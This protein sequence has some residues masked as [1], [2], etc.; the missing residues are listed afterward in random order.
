MA[1]NTQP[2]TVSTLIGESLGAMKTIFHSERNNDIVFREF[3]S[4]TGTRFFVAYIDGMSNGQ[5]INEFILKP[6]MLNQSPEKT[7]G[8]LVQTPGI[9]ATVSLKDAVTGILNGDAVLF[10]D[11]RDQCLILE[12]KGFDARS[13]SEPE[14]EKAI[15]GSRESFTESIRTNT[16]LIHRILRTPD[17]CCEFMQIG[18]INQGQCA[19]MYLDNVVNQKTLREV[20]KRLE[21]IRGDF[22][23]GSGMVEQLIEDSPLSLFPS[24]LST[25][26]PDRA[27]GYL[28]MGRI[29]ILCDGSPQAIVVPVS[30]A[31]LLDSPEGNTQRWQSGSLSRLI[32]MFAFFCSTMLSAL[33]L[34]LLIYHREMIPTQLLGNI[35]VARAGIPFPSIIEVLVMEL[36]FELV[37]E[38]G[39]RSPNA[40][41]S[42]MGIVGAL[43]LGQSAVEANLVS[44]VTLI[45]VAL[46]G[47]GNIA[48][49]DYDLAFGIRII[50]LLFILGASLL[51]FL[52]I[53][54]VLVITLTLLGSQRS[55][56]VSMLSMQSVCWDSGNPVVFQWP[57]WKLRYRPR[58]LHVQ[59]DEAYP[60]ISR[61]WTN[62]GVNID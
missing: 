62:D 59:R 45:V 12:A 39:L 21:E 26:R 49:P 31:L 17:L 1:E 28:A 32:R 5:T 55:F 24:I 15:K 60:K 50:K 52:G 7:G 29:V 44:P 30:L 61:K 8:Q 11:G 41:G 16:T 57:L 53:A 54:I 36:F 18:D 33:Y 2:T 6:V 4:G 27:S 14:T 47:L 43:I 10:E 37:R 9:N 3:Q 51:G 46:S 23:M 56:G 58:D 34:S 19:V 38:A 40:L 13:I 42:A 20:K 22:I 35:V 25:E 48:L